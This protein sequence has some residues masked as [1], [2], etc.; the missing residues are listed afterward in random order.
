MS[1]KPK[2]IIKEP[3]DILNISWH[4]LEPTEVLE[5]LQVPV[6]TGLSASEVKDRLEKFGYN[7][8]QEQ[9]GRTFWQKLWEQIN[10]FVIWLLIGAAV[11]SAVLG[12]W[13]EA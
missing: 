6:E 1:E 2:E 12:D 3:E 4:A 9:P 11:I 8:L 13:V 7:E 5:S 10:S